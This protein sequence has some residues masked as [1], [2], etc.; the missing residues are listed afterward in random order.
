VRT[1]AEAV[2][3]MVASVSCW[4]KKNNFAEVKRARSDGCSKHGRGLLAVA[5]MTCCGLGG[6]QASGGWDDG[7]RKKQREVSAGKKN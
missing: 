6:R 5:L 3:E 4:R 2:A 7:E 1:V